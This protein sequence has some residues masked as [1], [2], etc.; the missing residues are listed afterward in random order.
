M[1]TLDWIVKQLKTRDIKT[2]TM[3]S[4]VVAALSSPSAMQTVL[5]QHCGGSG[6]A[7]C[8]GCSDEGACFTLKGVAYLS[9]ENF[10]QAVEWIKKGEVS[11]RNEDD[12]WNIIIS[13]ILEG[14]VYEKREIRHRAVKPFQEAL[15]HLEDYLLDNQNNYSILHDAQKLKNRLERRVDELIKVQ[16]TRPAPQKTARSG[17][18]NPDILTSWMPVYSSVQ[19]GPNGPIWADDLDGN[20]FAQFASIILDGVPHKICSLAQNGHQ[21]K[22]DRSKQYGWAQVEGDSMS[23]CRPCPIHEHDYVLFYKCDDAEDGDIVI[24]SCPEELGSGRQYIVKRYAKRDRLLHSETDPPN[25]YP[26]ID[27]N[28]DVTIVGK[29]VM[30]AK[31]VTTD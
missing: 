5:E 22:L 29:V 4:R 24:S 9:L 8:F 12:T 6:Q 26:P 27:I 2:K 16:K 13:E 11:F 10:E 30:V 19:A 3:Q 15:N 23:A 25:K 20:G 7:A 28:G 21:V 17:W 1:L 31:R 14:L 18:E